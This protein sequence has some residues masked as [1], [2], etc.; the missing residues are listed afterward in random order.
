MWT[1][2]ATVSMSLSALAI[3]TI[4]LWRSHLAPSRIVST[5]GPMHMKIH[6][7]KSENESWL[8][9]H[10]ATSVNFTNSGSQI[11]RVEGIRA[12]IS[13]TALPIPDAYETFLCLGEY[14]A[15]RYWK[16]SHRRFEMIEKALDGEFIPLVILPKSTVTRFYVFSARWDKSVRQREMRV[17]VEIVTDRKPEWTRIGDWTF[18]FPE[19]MWE[20]IEAGSS[21][22]VRNDETRNPSVHTN[23][24]DLHKYTFDAEVEAAQHKPVGPTTEITGNGNDAEF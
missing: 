8:L 14:D 18:G 3:S 17:S 6:T 13:Y 10:F 19:G 23:P 1:T 21:L 20:E 16:H 7:M 2:I 4:T 24:P 22:I 15:G 11:G 5:F 9:P 12:I